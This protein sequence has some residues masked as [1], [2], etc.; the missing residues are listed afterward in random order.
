MSTDRPLPDRPRARPAGTDPSEPPHTEVFDAVVVHPPRA[1][2]G[3]RLAALFLLA[4]GVICLIATTEIPSSRE[5]WSVEGPRFVPLLVSVVIVVL[6]CLMLLRTFVRRDLALGAIA[7]AEEARTHWPTPGL[8]MVALV[9]YVLLLERLGYALATTLFFIA[10][11]WLLGS[12]DTTRD[13]VIG[14]V[15]GVL[16]SY[17]FSRLLGVRLPVGRF[18]V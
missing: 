5:G 8:V 2:A 14:L 6:S 13:C 3:P 11:S 9:A 18:G 15:L 7:A 4:V 16:T 12:R 17:A 1:W 10:T